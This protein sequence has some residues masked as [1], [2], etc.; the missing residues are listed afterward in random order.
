MTVLI[1][2]SSVLLDG[3]L[4]NLLYYH[5]DLWF[6]CLPLVPIRNYAIS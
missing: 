6:Q 5:C 1:A 4:S 3:C 2:R